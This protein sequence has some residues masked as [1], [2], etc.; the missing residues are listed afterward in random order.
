M[1]AMT[2]WTRIRPPSMISNRLQ[3]SH[4]AKPVGYHD[5]RVGGSSPS[6]GIRNDREHRAARPTSGRAARRRGGDEASPQVQF[7]WPQ[8]ATTVCGT[9]VAAAAVVDVAELGLLNR[10]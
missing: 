9:L 8:L 2:R 6:S 5:P 4:L 3:M 10:A 7:V 1:T